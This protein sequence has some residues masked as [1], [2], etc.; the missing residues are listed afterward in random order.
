MGKL[1]QNSKM[2]LKIGTDVL[3]PEKTPIYD[4]RSG[5]FET[6]NM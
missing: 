5:F 6:K 4:L 3:D 1:K 2:W